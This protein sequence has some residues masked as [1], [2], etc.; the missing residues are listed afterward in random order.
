MQGM[1][2]QEQ[3][4]V[5]AVRSQISSSTGVPANINHR[6]KQQWNPVPSRPP[7]PVRW[8]LRWAVPSACS[9]LVYVVPMPSV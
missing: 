3:A 9:W 1:S 2:D 7:S 4:M 6:C 8:V 5:K